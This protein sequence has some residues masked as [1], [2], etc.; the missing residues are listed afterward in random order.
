[1]GDRVA[2]LKDGFLQQV[3]SPQISTTD[4]I[5]VFVGGFIGSPSMNLYEGTCTGPR[6]SHLAFGDP[7]RLSRVV[8][9]RPAP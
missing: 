4:P 7:A 5:N 2:V 8:V 9:R 6:R 3:D 1:M